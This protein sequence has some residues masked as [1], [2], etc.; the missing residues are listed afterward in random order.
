MNDQYLDL[1]SKTWFD[2]SLEAS[3]NAQ[4]Q[5]QEIKLE[6]NKDFLI[7][8]QVGE[9]YYFV[10]NLSISEFEFMSESITGVLGYPRDISLPDF[11]G[12][13]HPQDL[14]Y[15]INFE[16]KVIE[17]LN[18][19]KVEDFRKYK[20]QYDFRIKRNDGEYIRVL[21]QV[22]VIESDDHKKSILKTF[23]M[24]TDITQFKEK[25]KPKLSFIGLE[26]Q[27]SFID[28]EVKNIIKSFDD[29]FTKREHEMLFLICRGLNRVQIGEI[30]GIS[31]HTVDTHRRSILKK[32]NTSSIAELV[33]KTISEGWI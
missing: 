30:L 20:V 6:I 15:F 28:V 4:I 2:T 7:F 8:S 25:G 16:N 33:A 9:S 26:G 3:K 31:K 24:H 18:D 29:M 19:L 11:F 5:E 22:V 23:V 21:H 14:P 13:I 32:S 10:F 27:P 17:F 12:N 1:I